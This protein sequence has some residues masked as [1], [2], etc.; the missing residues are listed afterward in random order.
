[1]RYICLLCIL[2]VSLSSCETMLP[3]VPPTQ[4]VAPVTITFAAPEREREIYEPLIARFNDTNADVRVQFIARPLDATTQEI[5]QLADTAVVPAIGSPQPF[6][7]GLADL[8]S[9]IDADQTFD[10]DDYAPA[11]FPTT[12]AIYILP[13][14][15]QV[16]LMHYHTDLWELVGL[17]PPT[18]TWT[19]D[20][21]L[22]A[23]QQLAQKRGD[24][25]DVYGLLDGNGG[26]EVFAHTLDEQGVD[27]ETVSSSGL[28]TA[29][30]KN[31]FEQTLEY[32]QSGVLFIPDTSAGAAYDRDALQ[33]KIQASELVI[34][35]AELAVAQNATSP[36]SIPISTTIWPEAAPTVD[37]GYILSRGSSFPDQAW[38]WLSFLSQQPITSPS[39]EILRLPAR[40]SLIP[41]DA[42]EAYDETTRTGIQQALTRPAPSLTASVAQNALNSTLV[43]VLPEVVHGETRVE[44]AI[45]N[46][47]TIFAQQDILTSTTTPVIPVV[48]TPVP[49]RSAEAT[50]ITFNFRSE[51]F[52]ETIMRQ[53]AQQFQEEY[54]EIEVHLNNVEHRNEISF[55]AMAEDGDCFVAPGAPTRAYWDMLLNMQP[56]MDADPT[57]RTSDYAEIVF[58]HFEHEGG[59]YGLPLTLRIQAILYDAE[60]FDAAGLT[61]PTAE[62]T[63]QDFLRTAVAMTSEEKQFYGFLGDEVSIVL[64]LFG[65]SAFEQQGESMQP[66]FTD[67]DVIQALRFF[68]DLL[69]TA[70][71]N[72]QLFAYAPD[73][74]HDDDAFWLIRGRQVGMRFDDVAAS[75][76]NLTVAPL[77]L[78]LPDSRVPL[79]GTIGVYIGA[80]V[81]DE[82]AQA[83]WQWITF[84]SKNVSVYEGH[85]PAY[86]Q[87]IE[88][89]DFQESTPPQIYEVYTTYQDKLAQ[90]AAQEV[91]DTILWPDTFWFNRAIDEALQRANLEQELAAAQILT[92]QYLECI[93]IEESGATCANQVD[94]DYAG[95]QQIPE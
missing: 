69:Q 82:Q 27:F 18:A 49:D 3:P 13:H 92:Q 28:E 91:S 42:L 64:D 59:T 81:S 50:S 10:Q 53:V 17:S 46:F 32:A 60:A 78:G 20:D 33:Q 43:Q 90:M 37:G 66:N 93:Q 76:G 24:A 39:D 15:L 80:D 12:D 87:L 52:Q 83:C 14:T 56:Y 36:A 79:P 23:A 74:P 29:V 65:A 25:I 40:Q 16:R 41:A 77:P 70:S 9:Y 85:L 6:N 57:F 86:Q 35:P 5:A 89:T 84:M 7:D 67:P 73:I 54:P 1:M 21:W 38:R 45:Q 63:P 58:R 47:Q 75:D 34:W 31:A 11:A 55:P 19:W 44:T 4:T 2:W 68:I 72:S 51:Y 62:W 71:P 22:I 61:Y 48:A 95:W 26:W 88:S 8:R 94:P 30:I